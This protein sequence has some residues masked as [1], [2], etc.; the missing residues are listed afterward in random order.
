VHLD[1]GADDR[2]LVEHGVLHRVLGAGVVAQDEAEDRREHQQQGEQR[3]E[4]VV[5][6]QRRQVARTIVAE[7][8]EHGDR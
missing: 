5:G 1:L 6:D 3:E 2:E 4:R 7:L 8:L